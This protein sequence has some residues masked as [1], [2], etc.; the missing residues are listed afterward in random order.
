M[1]DR[2]LGPLRSEA[3]MFRVVVAFVVVAVAILAVV[4]VIQAVS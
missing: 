2:L 3:D 1:L 4:L